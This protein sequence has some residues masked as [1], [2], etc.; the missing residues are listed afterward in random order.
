MLHVPAKHI[1]Q[2]SNGDGIYTGLGRNQRNHTSCAMPAPA[3]VPRGPH[4]GPLRD[5]SQ[6]TLC[7]VTIRGMEFSATPA[8]APIQLPRASS[9]FC[10]AMLPVTQMLCPAAWGLWEQPGLSPS[11]HLLPAMIPHAQALNY[12]LVAQPIHIHHGH[13][14]HAAC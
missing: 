4:L 8:Q 11:Q 10:P 1:S 13:R 3:W 6:G 14:L 5:A 12:F 2:D 9:F 7:S